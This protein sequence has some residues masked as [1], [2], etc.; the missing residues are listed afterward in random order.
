M[1]TLGVGSRVRIWWPLVDGS[2]SAYE[3]TIEAIEPARKR[4]YRLRFV[5]GDVRW[6]KLRCKKRARFD[7]LPPVAAATRPYYIGSTDPGCARA[8][9]ERTLRVS[10]RHTVHAVDAFYMCVGGLSGLDALATLLADPTK[11]PQRVVLFDRDED[12]LSFWRLMLS[13]IAHSSSRSELLHAIFGRCPTN[14]RHSHGPLTAQSMLQFLATDV[15]TAFIASVRE[16][17]PLAQQPLYDRIVQ[18]SLECVIDLR[19]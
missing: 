4:K 8:W 1:H 2:R 18:A 16:A 13:L 19:E 12:A 11:R 15:G 3:A 17:L 9:V 6:S 14:W 7:M 10:M 5:D